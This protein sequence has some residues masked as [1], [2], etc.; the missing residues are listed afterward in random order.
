[1]TTVG[2]QILYQIVE[3]TTKTINY[4]KFK[5]NTDKFKK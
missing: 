4:T 2:G 3:E 1:M 5:K